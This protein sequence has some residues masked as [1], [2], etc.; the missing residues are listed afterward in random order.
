V[1]TDRRHGKEKNTATAIPARRRGFMTGERHITG[2][3]GWDAE[4]IGLRSSLAYNA[5][6]GLWI[7]STL[8]AYNATY[9]MF[10]R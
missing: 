8:S 3:G 4:G 5:P 6:E 1:K 9:V 10:E 2:T 7:F